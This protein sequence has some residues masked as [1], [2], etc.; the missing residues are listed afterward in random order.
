MV[1]VVFVSVVLLALIFL[2]C[3]WNNKIGDFWTFF[4]FGEPWL[5]QKT[6]WFFLLAQMQQKFLN[7]FHDKDSTIHIIFLLGYNGFHHFQS[8]QSPQSLGKKV[9]LK[10]LLDFFNNSVDTVWQKPSHWIKV[11]H[12]L[13]WD[14]KNE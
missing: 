5:S 13:F 11:P 8:F 12:F 3:K 7:I 4:V 2:S 14:T 6:I 10:K 9:W 1:W